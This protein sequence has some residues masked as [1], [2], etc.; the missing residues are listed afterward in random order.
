ML[1]QGC[2]EELLDE[3]EAD[4]RGVA[5]FPARAD[6]GGPDRLGSDLSRRL[7]IDEEV[8]GGVTIGGGSDDGAAVRVRCR[9][10]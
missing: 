1:G 2:G 8:E 3:I 4:F 10:V 7:A 9:G 6:R 5:F